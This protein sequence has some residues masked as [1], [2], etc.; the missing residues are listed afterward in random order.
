MLDVCVKIE[1]MRKWP[2]LQCLRSL[3]SHGDETMEVGDEPMDLK[4]TV[5][6]RFVFA[7]NA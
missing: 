7:V 6:L 5:S 4:F 3:Q 1:W 2:W